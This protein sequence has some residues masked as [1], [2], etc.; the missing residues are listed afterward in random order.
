MHVTVTRWAVT[1]DQLVVG[2]VVDDVVENDGTCTA[3]LTRGD[4]THTASGSG[5]MSATNT[6][7]GDGLAFDVSDVEGAWS[8]TLSYESSTAL[9]V[10]EPIEIEIP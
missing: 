4:S 9:G 2:G 10:S 5:A 3:T 1:G 8:L 7:C 6:N